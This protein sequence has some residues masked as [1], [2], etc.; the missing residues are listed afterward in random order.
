MIVSSR[1]VHD[2]GAFARADEHSAIKD[3]EAQTIVS[4]LSG[5]RIPHSLVDALA[6]SSTARTLAVKAER[7][8][9]GDRP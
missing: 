7:L 5:G 6:Q 4:G 9:M 8:P 3:F 2:R 1:R